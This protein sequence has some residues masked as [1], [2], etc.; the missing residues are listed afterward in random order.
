MGDKSDTWNAETFRREIKSIVSRIS[1]IDESELQDNVLV[2]EELGIDSLMAMEIIATCEK[3]LKLKIDET[4]FAE[5]QT[6]EDF[7]ELLVTA[8]RGQNG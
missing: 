8:Y 1:R 3:H 6:V 2:R 5:V 4:A 7:L